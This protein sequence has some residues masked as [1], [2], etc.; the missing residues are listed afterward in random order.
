MQSLQVRAVQP[1]VAAQGFSRMKRRL[2]GRGPGRRAD[3]A[4]VALTGST[5]LMQGEGTE[6]RIQQVLC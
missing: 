5:A 3:P 2:R 1:G 4:G 6:V